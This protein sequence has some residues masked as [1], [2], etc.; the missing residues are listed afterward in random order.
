MNLSSQQTEAFDQVM[1]FKRDKSR[2]RFVLAGVAGAGKT[3]LAKKIAEEFN[4]KTVEAA[5]FTGKAAKVLDE[6]GLPNC[7]T[8]HN[9]IYKLDDEDAEEPTFTLARGGD[10]AD[11]KLLIVDEYSMLSEELIRDIEEVA[12]KVLYLGDPFQ[13]PPIEGECKLK[14][15]Y[16]LTEIHRQALD[17]PIIRLTKDIREGKGINFCNL[18]EL[19]YDHVKKI[20]PDAYEQADQVIVGYNKTRVAFNGRFREKLGLA[21]VPYPVINDKLICLRNNHV[22]KIYNGEILFPIADAELI[23]AQALKIQFED[24]EDLLVWDGLF[25][26]EDRQHIMFKHLNRFDYGYAI[27]CH[28]AQG[29]EWD[30]VLVFMQPM[31]DSVEK[32]RWIYT[33]ATRARKKL[34]LVLP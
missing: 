24:H 17:S 22:R 30:N 12:P 34:T 31:G 18:P 28:K 25:R 27:T 10:V 16:F 5:A 6:K 7:G 29:S 19:Q 9:K 3:T 11:S 15:D 33:A 14:P 21:Q 8:I 23:D 1:D 32:R 4:P 13:L 20:D 26:G 2:K